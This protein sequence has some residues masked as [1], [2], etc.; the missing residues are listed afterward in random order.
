MRRV[1]EYLQQSPLSETQVRTFT[2]VTPQWDSGENFYNS[3]PSV[4]LRWELLQQ[5]PQWDS[6]VNLY[7]RPLSETQVRTFTTVTPQWDSGENFCNSHPSVRLRWELLQQS[8]QWDSGVNLYNRPISE[9]QVR[10]GTTVTP[11]WDS[12]ENLYN[13]ETEVRSVVAQVMYLFSLCYTS[14]SHMVLLTA[15]LGVSLLLCSV[16]DQS[17]RSYL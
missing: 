12:G 16:S 1:W 9:T 6:G 17:I 14:S 2:T 3:H 7:N 4:R 15:F 10:T 11:Q 8:P 13:S 5:S